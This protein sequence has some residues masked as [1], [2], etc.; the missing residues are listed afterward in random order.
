VLYQ[1]LFSGRRILFCIPRCLRY[2]YDKRGEQQIIGGSEDFL[3]YTLS[4]KKKTKLGDVTR[5]EILN[6]LTLPIVLSSLGIPVEV[7]CPVMDHEL[8]RPEQMNTQRNFR[9][10][11]R[12]T[13]CIQAFLREQNFP[14]PIKVESSLSLF[15][16]PSK[17]VF[18]R[19]I[20]GAVQRYERNG[21]GITNKTFEYAV[22]DEYERNEEDEERSIYYRSREFAR[23]CRLYDL[24]EAYFNA[25]KM[26]E[27]AIEGNHAGVFIHLP[28]GADF[29]KMV[30]NLAGQLVVY[31]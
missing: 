18:F 27:L 23:L 5:K 15:G 19:E 6:E 9:K 13:E 10:I 8:L 2:Y 17:S 12:F 31:S 4:G 25:H 14:F 3:Y 30:F 1:S 24:G 11:R 21:Y 22:T 7:V 26:V 16:I 28:E 29:D 20:T